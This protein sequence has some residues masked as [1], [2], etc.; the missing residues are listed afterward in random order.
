[1]HQK[2]GD[3]MSGMKSGIQSGNTKNKFV[4]AGMTVL[5]VIL[6]V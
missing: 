6:T 1:M 3:E 4:Y 2:V 5:E